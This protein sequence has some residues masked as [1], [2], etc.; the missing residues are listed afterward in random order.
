MF[1]SVNVSPHQLHRPDFVEEL[2]AILATTGMPPGDLVLEMTE[3][4][5]FH[6]VRSTTA[7]LESLRARGVR[8]A[9]DDFGTG[10]SSLS[11]LRRFPVDILKIAREFVSSADPAAADD[12]WAIAHAIV[13][14]GRSLRMR[15]IAEGVEEPVQHQRLLE[16]GCEYGQGYLFQRPGAPAVIEHALGIDPGQVLA[17][18]DPGLPAFRVDAGAA[19]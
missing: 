17:R 15:I 18:M 12:P 4:A 5:M 19:L 6:D 9:I 14:L 16:L 1:I 13:A 3:T 11:Y 8:I 7:K 2:E 10:W